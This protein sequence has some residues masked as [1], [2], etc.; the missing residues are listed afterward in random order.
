MNQQAIESALSALAQRP[1]IHGCALVE[2]AS[3]LV[4]SAQG[5]LADEASLWEA[6]AEYW[7]LHGRHQAHFDRLGP[8]GAAVMYHREGVL[9]AFR[10][11]SDPELLLVAVGDHQGV[12]W[13]A[14]QREGR[15]IGRLLQRTPTA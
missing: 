10:C 15:E 3:G 13:I 7:R 1:G 6:G 4:W 9:A 5:R 14:M 2:A 11:A 8:L 12:D